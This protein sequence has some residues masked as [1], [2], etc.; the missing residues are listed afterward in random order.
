MRGK[1]TEKGP[2]ETMREVV[3]LMFLEALEEAVILGGV[4]VQPAHSALRWL[5][6]VVERMEEGD[7]KRLILPMEA[8][9]MHHFDELIGELWKI[10]A[11]SI[12]TEG[13]RE[14]LTFT[15]WAPQI[16]EQLLK[17]LVK[18]TDEEHETLKKL[19]QSAVKTYR[20]L[21]LSRMGYD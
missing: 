3:M 13:S 20:G 9:R 17:D 12:H 8:G 18:M 1:I 14:I 4:E 16:T 2:E 10:K 11:L 21:V 19:C 7:H 6:R 5:K 15:D